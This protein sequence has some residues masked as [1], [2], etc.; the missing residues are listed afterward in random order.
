MSEVK[1]EI[2]NAVDSLALSEDDITLLDDVA[3]EKVFK[4]CLNHFVKSGDRKWWWEDF[5]QPCF[6]FKEIEK[7]FEQLDEIIP[8]LNDKVW[9]IVED[10]SEPFYP[11][12]EV[13]PGIIK[14]IIGECFGFEYYIIDKNKK[15]LLCENHHDTMIGVGDKLREMNL[16]KIIASSNA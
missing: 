6:F 10:D 7:P 14:S 8:D 4:Y 15:W 16:D 9:L 2:A 3:G 5:K 13:K 1:A 12:Y 11:V